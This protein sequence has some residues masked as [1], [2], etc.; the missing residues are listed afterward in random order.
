MELYLNMTEFLKD[1]GCFGKQIV[2]DW[3]FQLKI[4]IWGMKIVQGNLKKSS[5]NDEMSANVDSG[6]KSKIP[7][8]KITNCWSI[9][10]TY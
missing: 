1:S 8:S 9:C 4:L 6:L 2:L 10:V 7:N 3:V 5:L